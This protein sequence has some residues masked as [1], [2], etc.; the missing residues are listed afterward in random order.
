MFQKRPGRLL[1]VDIERLAHVD[2]T[3]LGA[4]KRCYKGTRPIH[5]FLAMGC[6]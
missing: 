3:V 2:I 5:D 1:E 4:T 6:R